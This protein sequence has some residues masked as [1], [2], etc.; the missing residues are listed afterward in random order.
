MDNFGVCGLITLSNFP[1]DEH[2]GFEIEV[3]VVFSL[4]VSAALD[5]AGSISAD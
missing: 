2:Y 5:S 4:G 1:H 3:L